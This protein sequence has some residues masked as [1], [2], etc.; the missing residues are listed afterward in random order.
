MNWYDDRTNVGDLVEF[1]MNEGW[2]AD[3]VSEA[4]RRPWKYADEYE[5]MRVA[6]PR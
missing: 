2:G 4:V 1:L 3:E 6:N 5:Q